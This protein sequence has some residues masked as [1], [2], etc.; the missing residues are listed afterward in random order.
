MS[1]VPFNAMW[2]APPPPS[3]TDTVGV[4]PTDYVV[5]TTSHGDEA[6]VHKDCLIESPVLRFCFRKRVPLNTEAVTV[7]FI[8]AG[9]E[10][11]ATAATT[12]SA[13][14][15]LLNTRASLK[16]AEEQQPVA[17]L[18]ELEIEGSVEEQNAADDHSRRSVTVDVQDAGEEEQQN[19]HPVVL[20][21][22]LCTDNSVKIVFPRLNRAQLEVV[23]AYFYYK[24][25][26]NRRPTAMRPHFEIPS[27]AALE[28]MRVANTLKC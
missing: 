23:V 16:T 19:R 8:A 10:V 20:A 12:A 13:P 28:V 1:G 25:H 11:A 27:S 9:A 26:F 15:S 14:S 6:L 17:N 21:E 3:Y 2:T 4:D 5:L 22:S 24:H 7:E 18:Q